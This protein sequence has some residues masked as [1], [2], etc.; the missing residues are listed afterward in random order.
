MPLAWLLR[1]WP[2]W[3]E[4][5]VQRTVVIGAKNFSEQYILAAALES[6]LRAAG[7][8]V[9]RRDDLG[10]AIA[11]RAL[12]AGDIDAY[13]D[14][15]GTLWT[16]VLGRKDIPP[17]A[18]MVKE[19]TEE[20]E[21]RDRVRI[22]GPLGFENAYAFAM[23][24]ERAQ[25]L[26]IA[27]IDDLARK[28]ANLRLASDL[29]FLNRPEWASVRNQYRLRFGEQRSYSPTFMYR[30][31]AGGSADVISAFSSDGRIASLDLLTL[32]DPR[33]A[34][35]SYDA[36]LLLSPRAAR[37]PDIVAALEPLVGAIPIDRM[38]RANLMVDRDTDKRTPAEAARWL[39]I[40]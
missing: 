39:L 14:Y 30:A 26:G 27:T 8:D 37:D 38:R 23:R 19:L 21:Q 6:R 15:S 18:Q 40:D 35:P 20:L 31:I 16:N 12:A 2:P 33:G 4:I 34:L 28:A 5:P 7:Y 9:E 22:L 11:Y 32:E 29:E 10:S 25:A 13:V 24:R 36:V 3:W 1:P 17:A